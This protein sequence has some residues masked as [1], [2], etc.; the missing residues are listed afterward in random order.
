MID[1]IN[2]WFACSL[3][4]LV[5][6]NCT[7][8][9][10]NVGLSH[11]KKACLLTHSWMLQCGTALGKGE[12]CT[13][14]QEP[15]LCRTPGQA[16]WVG[17]EKKPPQLAGFWEP[18]MGADLKDKQ[19]W[20]PE[21]RDFIGMQRSICVVC[22]AEATKLAGRRG[23]CGEGPPCKDVEDKDEDLCADFASEGSHSQ[24]YLSSV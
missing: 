21:E 3:C 20:W 13:H 22:S 18:Q 19:Q 7:F 12:L 11:G 16:G 10:K 14:G 17:V 9:K 6:V 4:C 15:V 23:N 1:G 2:I 8:V 5:F 24:N